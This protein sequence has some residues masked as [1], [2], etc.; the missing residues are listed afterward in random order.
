MDRRTLLSLL[1]GTIVSPDAA[2]ALPA[3][4]PAPRSLH[5]VNAH[6]G[7][8]FEGQYRSENGPV[9]A[10]MQK[11]SVFL[12][13][14]HSGAMIAIDVALLDF[15]AAVMDATGQAS[16][17]VLSAYRTPATNAMLARTHFGVAENSQH[18]YGRALDLHFRTNLAEAMLAARE[19]RRGGIGWYPD[20]GFIHLDSGP[21]RNWDLDGSGWGRLLLGKRELP[22]K[23]D[24]ISETNVGYRPTLA[25]EENRARS[26]SRRISELRARARAAYLDPRR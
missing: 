17:V 4:V 25:M 13:D 2:Q 16:A 14:F 11:L 26:V 1:A 5:L 10:V 8:I 19:M 22:F 12:R 9:A 15:L 18:M 7:E 23:A 6:T 24:E 3:P 21:V 20:S